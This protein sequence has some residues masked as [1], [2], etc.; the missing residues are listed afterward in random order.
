M[1]K[2]RGMNMRNFKTKLEPFARGFLNCESEDKGVKT[3]AGM[4]LAA[5]EA[6]LEIDTELGLVYGS[7]LMSACGFAFGNGVYIR[8]SEM[9]KLM[10]EHPEDKEDLEYIME[11]IEP[12]TRHNQPQ[13]FLNE[14]QLRHRKDGSLWGGEWMGHSVPNFT[15]ICKYGTLHYREKNEK[16][17]ALNPQSAGLYDAIDLIIETV[18]TLSE[19]YYNLAC[20]YESTPETEAIKETFKNKLQTPCDDFVKAAIAFVMLFSLENTDSPGHFDQYMYD[21]WKVTEKEVRSKYLKSVWQFFQNTRT[22]NLC[23]SGSDENGS[24]LTNDL[25]YEILE[26]VK[27]YKYET[28]NLTMR[29]HP[30]T[31]KKLLKAA[32]EAICSGTGLPALYNDEAVCPALE[33]LGIPKEDSHRYIMNG[34]NQ[35]DIQGKSHMGLEDGEVVVAKAVEYALHN[36]FSAYSG[37]KVGLETG[38]AEEFKTYDEFYEAF[39]KQLDNLID[40]CVASSNTLQSVYAKEAP[41]PYRSM[42]IEGCMEKG[43]DYKNRGPVYGHGQILLEAIA[44]A[45]DS[46]AAIKKYVYE[47]KRFSMAELVNAFNNNF[48]GCEQMYTFLKNSPLKFGNDIEYVDSIASQ[49]VDYIN[50]RLLTI[51][52]WRGGFYSGGCSPFNRAP[53]YAFKLGAL[54][55]GKK[56][57]EYIIADSI[58]ATPGCD[59][60]GPTALLNSCLKFNHTLPGSGFILNLKFNKNIFLSP[61]GEEA[62]YSIVETYFKNKGQMLTFAVVS[63]EELK[64]AQIHPENHGGLIVR[65]GGYSDRFVNLTKE[66]QDHVIARTSI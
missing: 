14:E 45:A 48:E 64:D 18:E 52:T 3:A 23:I 60:N 8:P 63:E 32:Y 1:S 53:G 16:C 27:E 26:L 62:F 36:G 56:N 44:D 5:K 29:C 20:T 31:P 33:R 7:V 39:R 59:K 22:W 49:I 38:K 50:T 6:P 51:K 43:L 12:Y 61:S 25:T 35:I 28:P 47:E 13:S 55:N 2:E 30:G 4:L 9:E 17:R 66:L 34:C 10:E 40:I 42:L 15:D 54:P 65:V 58:G 21:F 46:L 57:K 24:D 37:E 19:R 11:N 41:N